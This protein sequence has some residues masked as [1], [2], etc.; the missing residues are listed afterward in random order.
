LKLY[1]A[2]FVV[3]NNAAK[4]DYEA[5]EAEV[6]SCITRFGGEIVNSIKWDER[7]M[8]YEIKRQKRATYILVHF[9]APEDSI[10]KI[11]RQCRLSEAILRV[12]IVVDED[13]PDSEP[14]SP[15][16]DD[17]MFRKVGRSGGSR[18][19]DSRH[20]RGSDDDGERPVRSGAGSDAKEE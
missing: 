20:G 2:M 13:G 9:N 4:E 10:S 12:L 15:V 8:A 1:E 18:R 14:Y 6:Q 11:E 19:E 7:R 5:V 17:D 3:N 16:R